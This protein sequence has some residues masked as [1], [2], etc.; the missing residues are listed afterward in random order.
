MGIILPPVIYIAQWGVIF[1]GKFQNKKKKNM[2]ALKFSVSRFSS[3]VSENLT[4]F[5]ALSSALLTRF[6]ELSYCVIQVKIG[7]KFHALHAIYVEY[8]IARS[9][10]L[11]DKIFI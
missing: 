1:A 4:Y 2:A 7:L 6:N 10:A 5:P 3:Q 11:P 8:N 9:K